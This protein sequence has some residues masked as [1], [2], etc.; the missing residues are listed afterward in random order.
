MS[1]KTSG[2]T[3]GTL[4][5]I[6]DFLSSLTRLLT[7][8]GVVL[9]LSL[10]FI[11]GISVVAGVR[12][13]EGPLPGLVLTVLLLGA[14]M[15][16]SAKYEKKDYVGIVAVA[17]AAVYTALEFVGIF[18]Y[19]WFP[20]TVAV[21]L[22]GASAFTSVKREPE[23][24]AEFVENLDIVGLHGGILLLIYSLLL[25]GG[26][27]SFIYAPVFPAVLLVFVLALLVTTI[28]YATRSTELGMQPDEL[29]HR[30]VS[31]VESLRGVEGEDRERLGEHV[32]AVADAL[33]GFPIPTE[34]SIS[35]GSIPVV[36]PDTD[37]VV[38]NTKNIYA[39]RGR[40]NSARFTGYAVDEEGNI[41][42]AKNGTPAKYYVA[43]KD[44]YVAD[45]DELP[46]GAFSNARVYT[47]A[48]AFIDSVISITPKPDF[49]K[50]EEV[51]A[52]KEVVEEEVDKEEDEGWASQAVGRVTDVRENMD[53]L[54]VDG[55]EIIPGEED[56]ESEAEAIAEEKGEEEIFEED[57]EED[58][59][60]AAESTTL[61]VGGDEIDLNDMFDKADE[62]L[63]DLE[64]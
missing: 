48:Y 8:K 56:L 60:P 9:L 1:T 50:E 25:W 61:D 41:L 29:H 39:L 46:A 45:A 53:S 54:L 31:V 20:V 21:F 19:A 7:V 30:L 10:S 22:I 13:V 3:Q 27:L 55:E 24:A 43:S 16:E 35:E 28:A 42:L 51:E 6:R 12:V 5:D 18:Q 52:S 59:K 2:G 4:P 63:E 44:E 37:P 17:A 23:T 40:L 64:E 38:Y 58:E 34:I 11:T 32:R 47:A 15:T 57:G 62:V 49:S 36:L 26:Q 33:T 14:V